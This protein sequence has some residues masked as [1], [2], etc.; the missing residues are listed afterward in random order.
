MGSGAAP[1]TTIVPLSPRPSI[2]E[3]ID[4]ELGAVARMARAPPSFCSS[5]AAFFAV[6]SMYTLAPSFFASVLFS[7]PRPI[8]AT[9]QG[10]V[11]PAMPANS[12]PLTLRPLRHA[13]A[14]FVSHVCHF[15]PWDARVHNARPEPLLAQY[16]AVTDS[17]SFEANPDLA[18][19]GLRNIALD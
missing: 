11:L 10:P 2:S 4:F 18:G 14:R 15:V 19:A 3:D 16:V 13:R 1:I 17:A 6:V 8:A 5:A 12:Q 9:L 7:V